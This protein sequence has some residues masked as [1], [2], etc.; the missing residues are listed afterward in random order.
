MRVVVTDRF[1]AEAALCTLDLEDGS[2]GLLDA[3]MFLMH[4]IKY[5]DE[6]AVSAIL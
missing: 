2:G 3:T 6:G 5:A 4:I 1:W